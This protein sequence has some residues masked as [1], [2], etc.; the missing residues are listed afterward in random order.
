MSIPTR[1]MDLAGEPQEP[2]V[3]SF[4]L[5]LKN[6]H[7][8][9]L[10]FA[11]LISQIVLN[12][13][14]FGVILLV[15]EVTHSVFM[16]GLA[17]T[18]FT[19]P[20]VPFSAIAGVVVDRVNKRHVLLVTNMLRVVTM[21]L[22][23]IS[24]LY[25][26]TS[27]IPLFS[28]CF[29]TS[30]ISQ[31]FVPAEGAAIPLSLFNISLTI[32]QGIGFLLVGRIVAALFPP[33]D[34]P[35]GAIHFHVRPED[36]LFI[37]AAVLYA[38]CTLLIF[39]IPSRVLSE[40]RL[41]ERDREETGVALRVALQS[42]WNDLVGG[43]RII[44]S[45]GLLLYA[46]IQLSIVG[47]LMLLI[48]E[49]AGAFVEQFL[50]RSAQDI[51]IVLAPAAIGLVL[52]SVFMTRITLAI[53]KVRLTII[54]FIVLGLCFFLLPVLQWLALVFDPQGVQTPWLFW[55][56]LSL[57]FMLG[58]AMSAVNIPSTTI[59]QE[60]A[61]EEGRAR[62]L[63]L[64]AMFYNAGSIPILLFAGALAKFIGFSLLIILI[65]AVMLL[66]SCWGIW[67]L[68]RNERESGNTLLSNRIEEQSP[69]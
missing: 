26:R 28:L 13:A 34:L 37:V 44:S 20:A 17:I 59:M 22:T 15:D 69:I 62:V 48:G 51:S 39:C 68:K 23:F 24:L 33:F 8:L 43:W 2:G 45:D 21:L 52:S 49:V 66:F 55:L 32:A 5:V 35:I 38:V 6:R 36:M 10:L 47:I 7:F 9:L 61:P 54:G 57:V 29:M 63:S 3:A 53:G 41:N 58:V 67:Y 19:L 40:T 11:Q 12:A 60:R 46:V 31:F 30:L 27:L 25:D 16:A 1:H 4:R 14:N 42:L 64:Q 65:A 50:H 56:T 18:A